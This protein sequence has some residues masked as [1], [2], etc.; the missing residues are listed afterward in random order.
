MVLVPA[1]FPITQKPKA[2]PPCGRRHPQKSGGAQFKLM[3]DNVQRFHIPLESERRISNVLARGFVAFSRTR[4]NKRVR[5]NNYKQATET[6]FAWE[7]LRRA[8]AERIVDDGHPSPVDGK[9]VLPAGGPAIPPGVRDRELRARMPVGRLSESLVQP[10]PGS[11]QVSHALT[12]SFRDGSL[13]WPCCMS[14]KLSA[15]HLHS[16]HKQPGSESMRLRLGQSPSS[17]AYQPIRQ[18]RREH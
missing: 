15:T 8:A 7:D 16:S 10:W 17:E 2:T 1:V 18:S 5:G 14:S 11:R 13:L 4:R 6:I 3:G 9:V 12:V